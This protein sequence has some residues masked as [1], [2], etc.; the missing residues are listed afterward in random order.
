MFYILTIQR[1]TKYDKSFL[2][3]HPV[4]KVQIRKLSEQSNVGIHPSYDSEKRNEITIE[5]QKLEATISR[6]VHQSRFHFL[7]LRFPYSY[8]KLIESGVTED[9]SMQYSEEI[10]F[11]AGTCKP[12]Y[13]YD[14]EKDQ[15][16]DLKVF[17]AAI[18]DVTLKKYLSLTPE[19]AIAEAKVIIDRVKENSGVCG[20][21]WHN[22]SFYSTEGWGGWK[23]VYAEL[24]SYAKA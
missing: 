14:I 22:S 16:T 21:V 5:K 12:F 20:L 18:M 23:E 13:W 7:R 4:F 6:K 9:H 8:R 1:R 24:L 17:P 10:G 2:W 19:K 3:D 15:R 11:R